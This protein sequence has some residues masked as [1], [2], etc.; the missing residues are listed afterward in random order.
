MESKKIWSLKKNLG[1]SPRLPLQ[2][3]PP[4]EQGETAWGT[5]GQAQ[6]ASGP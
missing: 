1:V 6:L 5:S 2:A 4:V 3:R